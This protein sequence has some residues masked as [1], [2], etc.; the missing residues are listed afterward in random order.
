M[1]TQHRFHSLVRWV[2]LLM[3][4]VLALSPSSEVLSQADPNEAQVNKQFIPTIIPPGGVAKLRVFIYNPNSYSLSITSLTDNLPP[5]MT[6]ANPTNALTTCSGGSVSATPGGTSFTLNGGTVPPKVGAINGECYFEVDIT[7]TVQGNSI[8]TIPASALISTGPNGPVTNST[9]ASA[10]LLIESMPNATVSKAFAP[11]TVFVGQNSTLTITINNNSN[12]INMTNV[13][14]TDVLPAGVII[15]GTATLTGCGAGVVS[16]PIGGDTITLTGAT[17]QPTPNCVITVP[18]TSLTPGIYTNQIPGG[19]LQSQQGVTDPTNRSATLSVQNLQVQKS[20]TPT[21]VSQGGVTRLRITLRNPTGTPYTG[22][23]LTD[24]LPNGGNGDVTVAAPPNLNNTCGGTVTGATAGSTSFSLSGGTIPAGTISVPGECIIEVD[25]VMNVVGT[26]TNTIPAG[27]VTTSEGASN[28]LPGSATI[29]GTSTAPGNIGGSKLFTPTTINPGGVSRIR[30]RLNRSGGDPSTP[31]TGVTFVDNLP[32]NVVINNP[33]NI[34]FTNCGSAPPVMTRNDPPTFTP[35]S[36]GETAFLVRFVTVPATGNC[37][38]FVDVTSSVPGVYVNSI[39]AGAITNSQGTTNTGALNATLTVNSGLT[40]SKQFV[41]ST[42]TVGGYSTITITLTNTNTFP[43][44]GVT[45]TDPLP[46][47]GARQL[48]VR[49]PANAS[50][51]CG[52][53]VVTAV[54]GSDTVTLTGGEILAQVAAVPGTCTI[55]FDVVPFGA[56]PFTSGNTTNVIPIGNVTSNQGISNVQPASATLNFAQLTMRAVKEFDPTLV[57]GGAD[58]LLTV[59]LTNQNAIPLTGANFV[60]NFPAGMIISAPVVTNTT[61]AGGVVTANAGDGFFTFAGGTIP[62]NGSCVV[63][64]RATMT[65]NGNLTN[66]IPANGVCTIEGVCNPDPIAA[67]LTNLPGV[68][69]SKVFVPSTIASGGVSTLV[70][71]IRDTGGLLLTNASGTDNLPPGLTVASPANASTT[72]AAGTVTAVSGGTT[73]TLSGATVPA[74]GSCTFQADVTGTV[75]DTYVNTIPAGALTTN[76]GVTN[77]QPATATLTITPAP[78]SIVKSFTPSNITVGGTSTLTLVITNP[79]ASVALTGIAVTD[80]FP[81]G[82]T[83]AAPLTTSNTCGGTLLDNLGGV[84]AAGAAGIQ[85]TGGNIAAAS[86]CTLTVNVTVSADGAYVNTTNN[87]TSTNGGTGNTG[88]ATLTTVAPPSIT[89]A[90]SPTSIPVGGVSTIT[91][92]ITNPNASTA[93]TGVAVTD[94]FPAG[95]TVATPPN[96]TN[97]CGGTFAPNAGDPSVS[98]SGGSIAAGGNCTL[99]VD[100]TTSVAG[101]SVNTTGNVTST[102]GGTGNTATATLTTVAPPSI[103][104]AFSPTSIPVGGVSTI[105]LVITNPNASTALTGVAVTDTFPAGMTVATPPNATNT[106]GGT[107]APNAGDPSVSLSGG[108]IAAGGNCTL[109]VDVTTSVAGA[110]VN[111]TGNVTSTNGGTGNTGSATL[112]TVA[113]PSITKAFSPTTIPAGGVTT[114]TLVITNPNATVALTGVAVTDTFPAGMTVA[115]P[116]NASNTCGGTFAPNAGDPSVSLSGGNIAAGGNCTLTVDVTTSTPGDS[117]NTTGNVTSTNGGTGNTATATV[118]VGAI[119]PPSIT[120]SFTPTT[121]AAGG[122][123]TL[124]LVITNPNAALTLTG[125]AVTDTFPTDMTVAA[126]LTT[127]NT[128]GGTLLDNLG[129]TLVAGAAGIQLTGGTLAPASNCTITVLVTATVSGVNT[130]GNVS[131]TNGGTGN[132][133]SATLTVGA[134]TPPSITKSFTPASINPGETSTLTLVITNANTALTLTG[135]AVTDTFP[136]DMTVAAPLTTTNTCGGT[137]LDNL[138]GTLVAGAVGIQL[139]GGSIAPASNCTITVLVTATVSGVNTTGN[140]SSTNGGTGNTGSATLTVGAIA[141]PSITKSFTPTTI[142]AGG[143][144][145]ITLVITNPNVALALTGVAVTDTFP[146]GMTVAAPPNATN[147]CGGTFA[148]VAGAGSVSLSGGNIAAGGNCTLTV[149]VTTSTLGSSVN[150]T[151]N[152]S[153]TNGGTGNTATATVVVN[154]VQPPSIVKSF[155]P[156]AIVSGGTTTLTLVISNPNALTTLTGVAVTDTFP[157]GMT[158]AAPLTTTNTCGGTLLDNLGGVLADGADGIQLTGGSI[159]P[160]SNCTITVLVTATQSGVNTTGNVSSTNGGTGNNGSAPISVGGGVADLQ[161]VKSVSPT[162]VSPGGAISFTIVLTNNGPDAANGATFSDAVPAEV[163]ILSATC[164]SAAGGAVCGSVNVAGQNVTMTIPT[165]PSGGSLTITINGI[166]TA[167][168]GSFTNTARITPPVDIVD[169]NEPNNESSVPV[170][171]VTTGLAADLVITKTV[172]PTTYTVGGALTYTIVV[173]NDGPND[174]TGATVTDTF[175]AAL[176]NPQWSCVATGSATCTAGLQNGNLVDTVDLAAGAGNFLTYTVT[177]IVGAGTTGPINNI[178]YVSLPGG[179]V[180]PTPANNSSPATSNPSGGISPTPVPTQIGGIV[181]VDPVIVKLVNPAL[182]LPG[183]TVVYTLTVTNPSSA[184][185]IGVV[186]S[187]PVPAVLQIIS[188]STTQGTFTISGQT[189]IFDVGVVNPGQTITLT[190]T[191]RLRDDAPAPTDV[192]NTGELRH[193]TGNPRVSSALLRVTRGR[194]PSTG[195]PPAE[196]INVGQAVGLLLVGVLLILMGGLLLRRV[197]RR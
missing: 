87:V 81:V 127:T 21:S 72:C 79:N 128:C 98:L 164:G 144:T 78:P 172:D 13:S 43:L 29:T 27:G 26:R 147:T 82:M 106:C 155:S 20:F 39:P 197:S 113:P 68:S 93:L 49:N 135:V 96:A 109:T 160:A 196:P 130:T 54:P 58:S 179:Y 97:T 75:P 33:P 118:T 95:M 153:S 63:Q 35:L 117:V 7:S 4:V 105:T 182:A 154:A 158:V 23:A 41:P 123:S 57:Y 111:T 16:A 6:V 34:A 114:I 25:V 136:T 181:I 45:L 140:V 10:T 62:P 195:L 138:G 115:T 168:S 163:S 139:T 90:F 150:T 73:I 169:P 185:A 50:T 48:R 51:T 55:T 178:A 167:S 69:I 77:A 122:T 157:T 14:L 151:S 121:I 40:V 37:D 103:T 84:L 65:V 44:T 9:P 80:T 17:V 22:V 101:A 66:V 30:V 92:V 112:N 28:A 190:I 83:V 60:D 189:V 99:T 52:A 5:G 53:G 12:T 176:I 149:D 170:V 88:S 131:S 145:T 194:L 8:N 165:F 42:I 18:V 3:L 173:R 100:V 152:V 31:L 129:G 193:Q 180:D 2:L 59:T 183:E 156:T 64:V 184:P 137:L 91:L 177:A 71:T 85:L 61:C 116:P 56:G 159:A 1:T 126:P 188:A 192:T 108:S 86:N 107:F 175:P 76:E 162:S 166:V 187:D 67:S 120:K 161:A 32:A 142:E 70:I 148:P 125:L 134:I 132:T 38:I 171:I 174:V 47:T 74:N 119:A 94:T 110:S 102:N 104:K 133:G 141:P 191:A 24:T 143:V 146:A 36:G 124:T 15:N 11:T 19:S 186:V 46:N 89:K